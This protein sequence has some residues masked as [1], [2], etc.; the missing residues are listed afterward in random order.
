MSY[1]NGALHGKKVLVTGATGFIGGR[2]AERLA[3]EEGAIVTGT[4]RS[5]D[6]VPH[7]RDAGVNLI[8]ADLLDKEAMQAAIAG[9][10]IVF[11]CAA[12]LL[13]HGGEEAAQRFNVDATET[14]VR[15]AATAGVQRV[16]HISSFSAYGPPTQQVMDESVPVNPQQPDLYGRTKA[17]G[18]IRA[19]AVGKEVGIEVTAVRP[20][21]VYGPRSMDWTVRMFELVSKGVPVIF[22]KADGYAYPVYID[23]LVDGILLT[24]V[25]PEAA[26]EAFQFCDPQVDWRTFFSHFSRMSGRKL[27]SIPGWA[28]AIMAWIV[29]TFH[30]HL[31]LNRERLKFYKRKTL[32]PNTKAA[33]LLGYQP[34]VSLDEGMAK[35]EAWLREAEYLS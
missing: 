26:G 7:V 19:F 15:L 33:T 29:E 27:R 8:H 32:Y 10:E 28:A 12:W 11:H 13:R 22:G 4:G 30:L 20:A 2:L 25:R 16:V 5:L 6:K 31:P 21:T 18:E 23:N 34:R 1:L 3:A 17:Q 14:V 35:S 24:A 9:N